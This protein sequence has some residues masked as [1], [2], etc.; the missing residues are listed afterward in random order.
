[1]AVPTATGFKVVDAFSRIVRLGEGL[2]Q[3]GALSAA[4]MDRAVAALTICAEK[5]DRRGVKRRRCIATQACRGAANGAE[6][7]ARVRAETGLAF[8]IISPREEARLA[9]VGCLNL[10]DRQVET[11]LVV[12]IGGGSTELSWVDVAELRLRES[13]GRPVKPPIGA[14]ASVPV[15]VV[16]LAESHPEP[17]ARSAWFADMVAQLTPR[18]ANIPQAQ[19]FRPHFE[20][21]AAHYVGTSGTVTSLA[22]VHLRLQRYDRDRVDGL[23]MGMA[24]AFAARD[25]LRDMSHEARAREP[26]IG[27]D[28]ADL[29]LAGCAILEAIYAAWP[30]E[31]L[32]VADRGL[33]EGVLLGLMNQTP[34]KGRPARRRR[35]RR[36]G[37]PKA[38][39]KPEATG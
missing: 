39:A 29:V 36:R 33:R 14:W 26:C 11:A 2:A 25:R 30:V 5:L 34:A 35:G 9:V 19:R 1:M 18:F 16:T 10:I 21:G 15:G 23:W 3:T 37:K 17:G 38:A 8:D 6:F 4:A 22:G 13:T 20:A 12:D 27:A 24:E 32:R 31:R 7:I 28:R